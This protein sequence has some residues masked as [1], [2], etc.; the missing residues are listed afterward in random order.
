MIRVKDLISVALSLTMPALLSAEITVNS[1]FSDHAV[2]QSGIDIPVWGKATEGES[3]TV[4]I[5]GQKVS[6]TVKDGYWMAR[7]TPMAAGGPHS[8]T[9]TGSNVITI[10]DVLVGEVWICSGQSNM[11]MMMRPPVTGCEE[12]KAQA[13]F[14]RIRQYHVG[15][16]TS[17]TPI[18]DAK[19]NWVICSP[20]TVNDYSAVGFFFGREL[21]QQLDVPVGL[22]FT[23]WGGTEAEAWTRAESLK[24]MPDFVDAINTIEELAADPGDI[25]KFYAVLDGWYAKNDPGS[26]PES[27]WNKPETDTS[28]W[29]AMELPTPWENNSDIGAYDGIVWYSRTIDLPED[30]SGKEAQVNLGQIDDQDTTWVN[31][32]KVGNKEFWMTPRE[33]N[34][35][36]GVLQTGTNTITIRVLD[37]G[38]VGGFCGKAQD[39]NI[40]CVGTANDTISLAG[41]WK[42]KTTV[43]MNKVTAVPQLPSD[44]PHIVSVLNNGMIAPL[45]PYAIRGAIW[46]QGES[47]NTRPTQ[48]QTLFP[49]MIKDWRDKWQQGNFPFLFVQIAPHKEMTPEIREA[50]LLTLCKSPNTAMAVTVDIGDAE[51]I[52]PRDKA[53]VGKRLALGAMALAYNKD[54]VYSGPLYQEM[55]IDGTKIKLSFRYAGSGLEARDGELRGFVIAG[56]D[57]VFKP[58]KAVIEGESVIVW[59]DE[60]AEP[61]AVRYGWSNVPDVNLY[62]KEGLPASP[63]RTDIQ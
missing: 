61:V 29:S 41:A 50:Q 8:M 9:I 22:L 37:T 48:Y 6:A 55:A 7:L 57:K 56:S 5:A 27:S 24:T 51:D 47:N 3:V 49:L 42:Y 63:F 43:P 20:D 14:P 44:N 31:G 26:N 38:G 46:Y 21:H 60:I 30:W 54:I 12:A 13:N 2:L 35:P 28:E 52:H 23:A 39:M 59:N 10:N 11:H 25:N 17:F 45:Q 19:S 33:Y 4:E 62:N 36:A 16:K 40:K 58:A 53:P 32:I 1:L 34:I 18:S 15:E